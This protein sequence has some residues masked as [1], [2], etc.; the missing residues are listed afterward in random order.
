MN[1]YTYLTVGCIG[2][3]VNFSVS[4]PLNAQVEFRS[5]VL[6]LA[7]GN[8]NGLHFGSGF[9]LKV[10]GRDDSSFK[11]NGFW[12]NYYRIFPQKV[13]K[14]SQIP[15]EYFAISGLW[16]REW[17]FRFSEVSPYFGFGIGPFVGKERSAELPNLYIY[18]RGGLGTS[19]SLGRQYFLSKNI[20]F[21]V[22]IRVDA[23]FTLG[24]APFILG[25]G[26]FGF[27]IRTKPKNQINQNR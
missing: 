15:V 20:G 3:L 17:H 11:T 25:V 8:G 27:W 12:L 22:E 21:N 23:N 13:Y 1:L 24:G 6:G 16:G 26:N 18:Y 5:T 19:L 4:V 10:M 7:G 14:L 9:T 2:C